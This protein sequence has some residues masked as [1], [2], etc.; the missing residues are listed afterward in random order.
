MRNSLIL[1]LTGLLYSTFVFGQYQ[2]TP[3]T[4][5]KG[6]YTNTTPYETMQVK[7]VKGK[8]VKNVILM[9]GDGM[10]L[11]QT[12]SAWVANH[13]HLNIDNCT[14]TGF[15]VICKTY[16]SGFLLRCS[17]KSGITGLY[18]LS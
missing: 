7:P 4:P 13:G 14:Y 11:V 16:Y 6:S 17:L 15:P 10:G 1:L 12:S 5:V 3:Y 18:C 9:I 2:A 8:K